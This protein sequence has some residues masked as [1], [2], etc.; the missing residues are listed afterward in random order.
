MQ[1]NSFK[2]LCFSAAVHVAGSILFLVKVNVCTVSCVQWKNLYNCTIPLKKPGFCY[3]LWFL[4]NLL[5]YFWKIELFDLTEFIVW[6]IDMST[7]LGCKDIGIRKSKFMTKT[8]KSK[9]VI[10]NYRFYAQVR[11][12]NK[13]TFSNH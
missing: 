12:K 7:T 10:T 2:I 11:E 13:F 4:I 8:Y 9:Y 3:N 6:N 5:W 1:K